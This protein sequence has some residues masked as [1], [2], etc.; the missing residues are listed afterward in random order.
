MLQEANELSSEAFAVRLVMLER[1]L[2]R[3]RQLVDRTDVLVDELTCD[4]EALRVGVGRPVAAPLGRT[5]ACGR[6]TKTSPPRSGM[7]RGAGYSSR[8]FWRGAD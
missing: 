6:D 7:F 4:F 2:K 5:R 1:K 3:V 8:W